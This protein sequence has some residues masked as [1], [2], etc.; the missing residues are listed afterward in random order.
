MS[1][2]IQTSPEAAKVPVDN[3][4]QAILNYIVRSSEKPV[5]YTYDPPPGI[6]RSTGTTEPKTVPIRSG[7][8]KRNLSLDR[9]GFQLV[10]HQSAVCDFYDRDEV[11]QVYYPEIEILLKQ[12][13]GAEKVLVFE[14][15][16]TLSCQSGLKK[17]LANTSGLCTTIIPPL[18]ARGGL[19]IICRS[20]R[21]SNDCTVISPK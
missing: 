4:V 10:R 3:S 12:T 20:R 15:F 21:V 17:T 19:A 14:R 11:E 2:R 7:R 1:Q 9:E 8:F 5:I 18:L 6:P 16:A 13:T